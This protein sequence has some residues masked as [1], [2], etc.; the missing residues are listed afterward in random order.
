MHQ[1]TNRIKAVS[2][3]SAPAAVGPYSQGIAA[4]NTIYVSGQ[5]PLDPKTME[6]AADT[7]AGQTAQCLA[8]AR[9][10]LQ[11]A[12]S[13][14]DRVVKVSVWMTDLGKFAEMNETYATFFKQPFPARVCC[15]VAALPKGAQVEIEMI[16]LAD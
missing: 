16:A 4:G 10:V 9:A 5:L 8:N 2:T 12:G 7:V 1:K 13:D 6:F 14:L 15:Q 11:A 3:Q